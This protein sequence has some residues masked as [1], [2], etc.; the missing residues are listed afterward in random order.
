VSASFDRIARLFATFFGAGYSPL[1]PGT[2]GTLAAVP[3][4]LLLSRGGFAAELAGFLAVAALAVWAAGRTAVLAGRKDPG[5]VVID[6]VAG[7]LLAMLGHPVTLANLVVGF[8]LFRLFDVVKPFPGR[9]LESLPGG[10]GIV[11]DDLAAGA[12]AWMVLWALRGAPWG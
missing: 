4:F 8:L 12:Y 11:L 10:W 3:L 2:A 7:F 6:E 9:Q 5:M 1:A